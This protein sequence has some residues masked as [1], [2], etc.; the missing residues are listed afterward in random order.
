MTSL[1]SLDN[2]LF[3]VLVLTYQRDFFKSKSDPDSLNRT[4]DQW[5]YN[6]MLYQLSYI[7]V[8]VTDYIYLRC[9]S[10]ELRCFSTW[11]FRSPDLRLI[12]HAN[13]LLLVILICFYKSI[14]SFTSAQIR[15]RTCDLAIISRTL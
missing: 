12:V 4:D 6:P 5:S 9:S 8:D 11:E 7:R 1:H 15:G 2:L 14:S 13:D 3:L 10:P